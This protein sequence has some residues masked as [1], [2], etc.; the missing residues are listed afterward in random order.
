MPLCHFRRVA[1]V[2]SADPES[3]SGEPGARWNRARATAVAENS[4]TT[5][6]NLNA[7]MAQDDNMAVGALQAIQSAG[8]VQQV[9]L[10]SINS[11][12]EGLEA[13]LAEEMYGSCTQSPSLREL[14]RCALPVTL[15]T[16]GLLCRA[17]CAMR[18]CGWTRG[19][20]ARCLGNRRHS[21]NSAAFLRIA[22]IKT[23]SLLLCCKA[24][25]IVYS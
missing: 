17:G 25:V 6:Q 4:L 18:C 11:S 7:I 23:R 22:G 12:K 24:H 9:K 15:P 20:L 19:M 14:T 21:V 1:S 16:A 8:R 5:Y 2:L 13:I 3:E 10:L